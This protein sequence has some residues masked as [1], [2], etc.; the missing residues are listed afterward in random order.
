MA[1]L[2]ALNRMDSPEMRAALQ[3][4]EAGSAGWSTCQSTPTTSA[5][6]PSQGAQHDEY[7]VNVSLP[8]EW[9]PTPRPGVVILPRP[10]SASPSSGIPAAASR[11]PSPSA[12]SP[13]SAHSA[14]SPSRIPR[15]PLTGIRRPHAPRTSPSARPSVAPLSL[16]RRE[17]P[18]SERS[19]LVTRSSDG[20]FGV[21]TLPLPPVR[22]VPPPLRPRISMGTRPHHAVA[23]S[24]S[25]C[26][27]TSTSEIPLR[28]T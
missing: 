4:G 27:T 14:Q 7:G 6:G 2:R 21:M 17:P 20:L 10:A 13:G 28:M 5:R 19:E 18:S 12:L 22:T 1:S 23:E 15:I 26:R 25:A 8:A 9:Q 11:S 24:E 16:R 3:R